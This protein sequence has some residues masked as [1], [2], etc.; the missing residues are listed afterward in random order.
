MRHCCVA[1]ASALLLAA[2]SGGDGE[3]SAGEAA[4]GDTTSPAA[5]PDSRTKTPLETD[6]HPKL[7]R[8]PAEFRGTWARASQACAVRN[9]GRLTVGAK[10]VDMFEG[11]GEAASISRDGNAL[12]V[13]L[14]NGGAVYLALDN[15]KR[16]RVR[17]GGGESLL[18]GR[19][20]ASAIR[21]EAQVGE[22]PGEGA[23][24]APAPAVVPARFVGLYAPDRT[25]CAE[26]Y[27]YAPAFR[28]VRVGPREV[29]FFETGGPVTDVNVEGDQIAITLRERIGEGETTRAVYFALN[30]DGTARY[31]PGRTEPP[32]VFVRCP[33]G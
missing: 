6:R 30:G 2:C 32:A 4:A 12:A 28:N 11:G 21:S 22:Q 15:G 7:V 23:S 19:C 20:P 17:Q 33:G 26:D 8:I 14:E 31:R 27:E 5:Q 16:M 10:S 1:I 24:G 18:Y 3:E 25:A 9:H 29:R 13:T